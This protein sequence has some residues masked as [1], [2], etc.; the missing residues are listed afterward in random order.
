MGY[1]FH[2]SLAARRNVVVDAENV[3]VV[4]GDSG[5]GGL[6]TALQTLLPSWTIINRGVGGASTAQI[7]SQM[8]VG[9]FTGYPAVGWDLSND[10]LANNQDAY[11]KMWS[12]FARNDSRILFVEPGVT[13]DL[14]TGITYQTLSEP[15]TR[16]T[17]YTGP[18]DFIRNTY[19]DNH[20]QIY[21]ALLDGND[22]SAGDL[23]DVAEG[24]FP[25][26]LRASGDSVHLVA[27]GYNIVAAQVVAKMTA[28]GW[29]A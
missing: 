28:N 17:S 15:T 24:I 8:T 7:L 19:P 4:F 2:A 3:F 13:G 18:R 11:P 25:R 1:N 6:V 12:S 14:G 26:S 5:T 23:A 9:W 27:A 20:V 22:G 21:Q 16:A 29:F 10:S